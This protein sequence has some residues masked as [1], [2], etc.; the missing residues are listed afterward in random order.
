MR[1]LLVCTAVLVLGAVLPPPL[2][3]Q[4]ILVGSTQVAGPPDSAFN[5]FVAFLKKQ[6]A[7]LIRTDSEHQRVEAKVKGSDES[8]VFVFSGG[9][10]STAINAQGTKGGTAAMIFGLGTV[11]DWIEDRRAH[12]AN[13]QKP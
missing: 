10:D 5:S 4:G 11:N 3:A 8:I 1:P 12:A 6:G 9:R 7:S 13:P 2:G